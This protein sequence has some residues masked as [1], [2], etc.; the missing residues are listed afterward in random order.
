MNVYGG[1]A[2]SSGVGALSLTVEVPAGE[3]AIEAHATS[4]IR[5]CR[6][7]RNLNQVH[8][9]VG[10]GPALECP[11]HAAGAGDGGTWLFV[12]TTANAAQVTVNVYTQTTECPDV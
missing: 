5:A 7:T 3:R 11:L 8:L 12:G 4:H 1:T 2:T 10:I 9:A 6:V